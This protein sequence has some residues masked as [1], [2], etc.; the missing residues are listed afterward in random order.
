V[1]AKQALLSAGT[2]ILA[3]VIPEIA[4]RIAGF[5]FESG[6]QFGWPR[7][8]QMAQFAPDEK[9]LWKLRP[10]SDP[11]AQ[12]FPGNSIGF[13]GPLPA[14]P[15]PANVV[16]IL[17]LGDSCTYLGYPQFT[18]D[19]L[20][21][22]PS[23]AARNYDHVILAV[24]GYSS[25]Q[26]LV[27]AR[28]YG[29]EFDADVA[30]VYFGWNDHWSAYGDIDSKKTVSVPRSKLAVWFA[31]S[32]RDLRLLQAMTW[33]RAKAGGTSTPTGGVRVPIDEYAG[34]LR[35]IERVFH[36]HGTKVVFVTAPTSHYALG[37]PPY[38]LLLHFVDSAESDVRLHRAY[39]ETVRDVARSTGSDLLDLEK[40]AE[41]RDDL[42]QLF[43][44]DGIHFT[45]AGNAWVGDRVAERVLALE[46]AGHPR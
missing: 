45:P 17:F 1:K 19:H 46:A 26:G 29:K 41:S 40:E 23:D 42:S 31:E 10:S 18:M 43:T 28:E 8:Q 16:R 7:P 39:N 5:H 38:L 15:K 4:L 6:I 12:K 37:V 30:V 13:S 36:E 24:P 25:Y 44:A 11:A 21:R 20:S 33:L 27:A 14:L 35:A 9:L 32:A 3:L 34:N 22:T 2:L